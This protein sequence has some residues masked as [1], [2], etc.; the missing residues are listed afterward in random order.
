MPV[1]AAIAAST[2]GCSRSVSTR[3]R[4]RRTTRGT[5][6][7]VIAKITF[8]RLA[9]VSAISA[10]ASSTDGIDISPSITR[11]TIA[12]TQRMKPVTSPI[13]SPTSVERI[14]TAKPTVSDTRAPY[15]T[16]LYTSRPSM[17][18]PNQYSPDGGA[19]ALAPA[20]APAGRPC[21]AGRAAIAIAIIA[22]EHRRADDRGRMAAQRVLEPRPG[23][24]DRARGGEGF[25]DRR[26]P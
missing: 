8:S 23:R 5:S 11:I 9:F 12:S 3:L 14:A 17:S 20:T 16:R 13:A 15:S 22:S 18:V 6:A 19:Q 1:P 10:I 2:N 21:R 25:R 24:R 7:I 4:T 26:H